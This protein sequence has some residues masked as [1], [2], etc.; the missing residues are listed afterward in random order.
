MQELDY[1]GSLGRDLNTL[2]G[3]KRKSK[4]NVDSAFLESEW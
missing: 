4:T 1:F 3:I 2:E